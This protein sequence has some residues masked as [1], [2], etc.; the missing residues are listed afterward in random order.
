MVSRT[1]TRFALMTGLAMFGSIAVL[2]GAPA[3][4]PDPVKVD[5]KHYNV[6]FENDQVRV[7]RITYGPHE[8]S[9]MHSHP[10]GVLVTL[11]DSKITMTTPDGKTSESVLK[12]GTASW[13][14]ATTHL[15]E[16]KSD[17]PAGE[18]ILVELKTKPAAA[19]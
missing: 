11:G 14:E 9:V 13:A 15:P 17:K 12:A 10:A 3:S 5:P 18:N 4:A 8:K 2:A 16:N 6:V 19:K 1:F 7:L